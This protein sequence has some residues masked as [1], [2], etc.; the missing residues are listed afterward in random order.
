MEANLSKR[1][2]QPRPS[3]R[4]DGQHGRPFGLVEAPIGSKNEPNEP[5]RLANEP[6]PAPRNPLRRRSPG[7]KTGPP[8]Q[9]S[10][11][12]GR[13]LVSRRRDIL[14]Y[15]E[16]APK[17][18]KFREL[19]HRSGKEPDRWSDRHL[20]QSSYHRRHLSMQPLPPNQLKP[21]PPNQRRRDRLSGPCNSHDPHRIPHAQPVSSIPF[22]KR[23]QKRSARS[24]A[25][26]PRRQTDP[27]HKRSLEKNE[28][29]GPPSTSNFWNDEE[30]GRGDRNNRQESRNNP[31]QDLV[32]TMFENSIVTR[33]Y[34]ASKKPGKQTFPKN[35]QALAGWCADW[36]EVHDPGWHALGTPSA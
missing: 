13:Q 31:T 30:E 10:A 36:G 28:P 21:K 12:P 33:I 5:Q 9:P 35:T 29:N 22:P 19:P 24:T 2:R 16:W 23:T 27:N 14:S 6:K 26:K 25:P 20:M 4:S 3:R 1:G 18:P 8:P 17:A 15:P 32:V 34:W 7:P 11:H